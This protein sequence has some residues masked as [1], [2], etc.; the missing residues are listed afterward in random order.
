[1]WNWFNSIKNM[2]KP[3]LSIELA[4]RFQLVVIVVWLDQVVVEKHLP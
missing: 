4:Y 2:A 3:Q 1:M